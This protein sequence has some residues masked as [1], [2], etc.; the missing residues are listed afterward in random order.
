MKK[1]QKKPDL[2]LAPPRWR[3][4]SG[5]DCVG[6]Y[7]SWGSDGWVDCLERYSY[8]AQPVHFSPANRL[9]LPP[10]TRCCVLYYYLLFS[11]PDRTKPWPVEEERKIPAPLRTICPTQ[12]HASFIETAF[13]FSFPL[14]SDRR[15]LSSGKAAF[16]PSVYLVPPLLL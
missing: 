2:D 10:V 9:S 11:A 1:V 14:Y 12:G 8:A 3:G 16:F 6:I 5:A 15:Q 7:Q 13:S 4:H